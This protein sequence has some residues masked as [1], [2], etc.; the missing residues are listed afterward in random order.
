M[1]NINK[2]LSSYIFFS[3]KRNNKYYNNNSMK[4]WK[5]QKKYINFVTNQKRKYRQKNL[6][7]NYDVELDLRNRGHPNGRSKNDNYARRFNQNR[8]VGKRTS[9]K[10]LGVT[11]N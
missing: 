11:N 5:I 1:N 7:M 6:L 2:L 9:Q 3:I 8:K 10:G 4:I